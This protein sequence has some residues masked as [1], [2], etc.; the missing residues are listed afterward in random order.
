[1]IGGIRLPLQ[2]VFAL[3]PAVAAAQVDDA[4]A[5]A[6]TLFGEGE[7][8]VE[9]GDIA[10]ARALFDESLRVYPTTAAAFNSALTAGESGDP[11]AALGTV[12]AIEDGEFGPVP[13]DRR[14]ELEALRASLE[15]QVGVIAIAVEGAPDAT[16]TIDGRSVTEAETRVM[17]GE[18]VVRVVGR[19][20]RPQAR[21]VVVEAGRRSEVAFRFEPLAAIGEA[22]PAT[23]PPD[24]EGG[25]LESPWFWIVAGVIAVAGGAIALGLVLADDGLPD[26]NVFGRVEASRR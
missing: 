10:R 1:M 14:G 22:D 23:E 2:V 25:V 3:V 13:P 12:A 7:A 17:P 19:G 20:R 16:R 5:R 6:R 24:E 9:R 4:E 18:H 21:S 8:A 11:L 15:A 26:G